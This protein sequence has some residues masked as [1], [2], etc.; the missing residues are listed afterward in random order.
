MYICARPDIEYRI[1]YILYLAV[2]ALA[3]LWELATLILAPF[4]P[5]LDQF[6][7]NSFFRTF[8]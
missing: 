1:N 8:V 7:P 3:Y 6:K 4:S 5:S 2:P